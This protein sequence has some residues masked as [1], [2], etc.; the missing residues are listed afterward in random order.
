MLKAWALALALLAPALPALADEPARAG[1]VS[2]LQGTATVARP[3]LASPAF[4]KFRDPVFV[5]DRIATGDES[6]VRIL[7]GDKAVVTI[8]ERSVVVISEAPGVSTVDVAS[9]K[10]AVAVAREKLAA[11]DL[12]EIR[13]P[14]AVAGIRGTVVIA[15][16]S[17]PGVGPPT[18]SFT[19]LN[20]KVSVAHVDPVSRRALGPPVTVGALE[21][22]R[23]VGAAP[24]RTPPKPQAVSPDTA[25]RVGR[26][27][28]MPTGR[29]AVPLGSAVLQQEVV[30][31]QPRASGAPAKLVAPPPA[32][33][34]HPPEAP[35]LG[36]KA[37]PA[38]RV[39]PGPPRAPSA[40][41]TVVKPARPATLQRKTVVPPA[42][43]ALERK[44]VVPP[45]AEESAT[46]PAGRR[47][48]PGQL[49]RLPAR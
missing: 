40:P 14:N 19:V 8:R 16:V 43:A 18:S 21:R 42:P 31:I 41:T 6:L 33:L 44:T 27:F 1:V 11:G 30:K 36:P 20:G 4:L 49:R 3:A 23:V 48:G 7:V 29:G 9:G 13:T 34:A 22:L 12:V 17:R 46:P 39:L 24:P 47:V 32:G 25:N 37:L 45:A 15:E 10:V 38:P 35:A 28:K 5:R 2:T 26:E